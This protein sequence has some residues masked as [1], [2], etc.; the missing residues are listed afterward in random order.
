MKT[1]VSS[2]SLESYH[3]EIKGKK[4]KTENK[5]V[6]ACLLKNGVSLTGRQISHETEIENSNV[7]RCLNDLKKEGK[8]EV[9]IYAK[10]KLTGRKA[11]HY[12]VKGTEIL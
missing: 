9:T 1:N 5:K 10:C 2:T 6:L 8:V 4:D 7:A 11:Q 3:N 12:R